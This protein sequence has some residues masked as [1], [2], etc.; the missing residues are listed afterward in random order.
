[1]MV[2]SRWLQ[3][4][5]I[6]SHRWYSSRRDTSRHVYASNWRVTRNDQDCQCLRCRSSSNAKKWETELQALK[7]TNARLTTAL[8]ES[9]TNV[10]QWHRQLSMYKEENEKYKKKVNRVVGN[11]QSYRTYRIDLRSRVVIVEKG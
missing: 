9:M 10:D 5:S 4:Q 6:R 8:Q 1:M 2:Q 11:G 7:N 3:V